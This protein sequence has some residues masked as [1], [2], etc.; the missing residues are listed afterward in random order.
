MVQVLWQGSVL[1][2]L[3]PWRFLGFLL[4]YMG[5]LQEADGSGIQKGKKRSKGL[6]K[7]AVWTEKEEK[8]LGAY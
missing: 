6:I 1:S 4:G 5:Q 3:D 8:N 2:G 7:F